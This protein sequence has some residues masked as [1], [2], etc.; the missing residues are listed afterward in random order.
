MSVYSFKF[1]YQK[2][3]VSVKSPIPIM[4]MDISFN[5]VKIWCPADLLCFLQ[6][7]IHLLSL[8]ISLQSEKAIQHKVD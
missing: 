4:V 8:R 1:L 2:F 5:I 3:L 6:N 7:C